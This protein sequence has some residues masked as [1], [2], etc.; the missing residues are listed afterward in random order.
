VGVLIR[1][2]ELRRNI[3]LFAVLLVVLHEDRRVV[4]LAVLLEDV[5]RGLATGVYRV[6]GR[7]WRVVGVGEG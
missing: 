1:K 5:Y 6:L 4:T 2:I 3:R 7:N